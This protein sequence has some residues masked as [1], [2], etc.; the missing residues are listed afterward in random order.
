VKRS[1]ERKIVWRSGGMLEFGMEETC[2]AQPYAV[3]IQALSV[4]AILKS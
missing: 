3:L 2:V 1:S 4:S